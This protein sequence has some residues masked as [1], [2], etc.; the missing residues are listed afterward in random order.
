MD[1]GVL[2]ACVP[3]SDFKASQ[4]WYERFFARAADV[5]AHENE[6]MWRV[7]DGGW[8]YIVLDAD[9]AGKTVVAM[10]VSNI[11]DATAALAARGVASGPVQ[12]AGPAGWKALVLDPDGNSIEIIEVAGDR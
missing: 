6:V 3:V 7:S 8:L 5:V 4:A 12:P 11:N 9:R 1:V 2:F 10:A